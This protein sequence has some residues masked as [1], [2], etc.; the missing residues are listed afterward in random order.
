MDLKTFDE[1]VEKR[2]DSI[3]N[4]LILMEQIITDRIEKTLPKWPME[5]T[6]EMEAPPFRS[7][8][9]VRHDTI[10]NIDRDSLRRKSAAKR[11]KK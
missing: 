6:P 7:E 2:L 1:K 11:R 8:R 10:F 5:I 3:I 9:E 4:H